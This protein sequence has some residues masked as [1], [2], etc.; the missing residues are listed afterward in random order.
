M[1]TSALMLNTHP[2]LAIHQT[3]IFIM[4]T[5]PK[6]YD[7]SIYYVVILFHLLVP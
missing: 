2:Y 7:F 4:S 6:H 1:I 5:F 3:A